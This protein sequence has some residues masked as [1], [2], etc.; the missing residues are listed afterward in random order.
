[1]ADGTTASTAIGRRRRAVDLVRG[2]SVVASGGPL[3][4]VVEPEVPGVD[5][6]AW[7]AGERGRIADWLRGHGAMLFRG[8]DLASPAELERF[9]E[10]AGTALFGDYGDLP[11]ER[12]SGKVYGTTPYPADRPI[13]FHN[14]SSHQHRFPRRIF[15]LCLKA[16]AS[17]GATPIVDGRRVLARLTPS[18]RAAFQEKRLHYVRNF[19]PGIDV[20]WQEFFRTDE[21]ARAE[22]ACRAARMSFEWKRAGGLRT[23][24]LAPAVAIH[25]ESGEASFFNQ[26]LL[27]HPSRLAPEVRESLLALMPEEDLPRNVTFGDGTPIPDG[28]VDEVAALE[29][30]LAV[31]SAWI[32]GDVLMVENLL[33]AHGRR[34]YGGARKV[35]VTMGDMVEAA[36]VAPGHV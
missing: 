6:A 26:I 29:E 15:F 36:D 19:V 23:A 20:P 13:L 2:P 28:A 24:Q 9:A 10:A 32:E 7:A 4:L 1:M 11:R 27:H 8:F 12:H 21:K 5:L 31:E 25:P 17:G 34:P 35:V 30:E 33:V 14:E 22:A 18:L 16:A 3:P